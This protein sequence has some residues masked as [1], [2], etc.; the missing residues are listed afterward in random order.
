VGLPE[1]VVGN[2][3]EYAILE[4]YLVIKD[5]QDNFRIYKKLY[6]NNICLVEYEKVCKNLLI[7]S[8][9]WLNF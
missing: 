1:N 7:I 3:R 9:R 2:D 4:R 6:P 8:K 5:I